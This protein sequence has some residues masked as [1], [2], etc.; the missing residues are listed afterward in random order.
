MDIRKEKNK[1]DDSVKKLIEEFTEK[2]GLPVRDIQIENEQLISSNG[3]DGY[4]VTD[5]RSTV[6]IE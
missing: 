6:I 2:T 3:I 5:A 4:I 1:L